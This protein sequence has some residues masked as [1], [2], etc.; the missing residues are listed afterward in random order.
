MNNHYPP[1]R[2]IIVDDEKPARDL[3]KNYITEY[4][5]ELEIVA[6][7][8]S[9]SSAYKAVLKHKPHLLFLDI[10]MPG[11]NGFEFL[12]RIKKVDFHIVFITAYS[13]YATNAFRVSAVDFLTKPVKITELD[14]AVN[15][16]KELIAIKA[17]SILHNLFEKIDSKGLPARKFIIPNSHGFSAIDAADIILCEADGYC[18]TFYIVNKL[19]ITSSRHL[20]YYSELLPSEC[21][22][23]VHNSFI[24]NINHVTS[25]SSQGEIHLSEGNS[26]P[27]SSSHKKEFLNTFR[28][29]N[30]ISH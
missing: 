19:K 18:T 30:S 6:M 25:Y 15:K 14:E 22:Q 16:V 23:R 7:C 28:K 8:N 29:D 3:I 20:R 9:A 1:I 21:F 17:T 24:I 12:N 13:D 5:P 10:E 27:L 11:E 4:Y 26:C 2:T